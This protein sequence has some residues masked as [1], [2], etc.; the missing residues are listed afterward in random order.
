[1]KFAHFSH[2][3]GKPGMTP[4]QRYEELWRELQLC[5]RLEY[6]YSFCVA[7]SH[8][9]DVAFAHRHPVP[10]STLSPYTMRTITLEPPYCGGGALRLSPR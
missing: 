2:V 5:D 3:W 6:D 10:R 8:K 7:R 9:R 1:M 4:H